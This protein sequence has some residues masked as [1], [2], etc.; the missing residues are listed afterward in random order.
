MQ[1][2]IGI[3][4]RHQRQQQCHLLTGMVFKITVVTSTTCIKYDNDNTEEENQRLQ[5]FLH[6]ALLAP[7]TET[8][9]IK[10]RGVQ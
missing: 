8:V 7:N 3:F 2:C 6:E 1:S 10:D 9:G 4:H 5:S